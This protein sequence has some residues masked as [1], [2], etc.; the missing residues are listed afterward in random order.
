[1]AG[2]ECQSLDSLTKDKVQPALTSP[3]VSLKKFEWDCCDCVYI[4]GPDAHFRFFF[5]AY[6]LFSDRLFTY[7]KSDA[8]PIPVL[9][10]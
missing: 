6:I 10:F 8:Y 4:S 7:F 3:Y 5:F 9:T 2:E 1:M